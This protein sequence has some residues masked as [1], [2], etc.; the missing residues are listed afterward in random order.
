VALRELVHEPPGEPPGPLA[1][2]NVNLELGASQAGRDLERREVELG[3]DLA[4][5]LGELGLRDA[6]DAH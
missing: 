2:T 1:V 3:A 6:E 4:Q 5:A